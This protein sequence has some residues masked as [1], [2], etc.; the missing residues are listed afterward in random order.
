MQ[1]GKV[2]NESLANPKASIHW[3]AAVHTVSEILTTTDTGD[4]VLV[5]IS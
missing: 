1:A 5:L 4:G 2:N 3:A